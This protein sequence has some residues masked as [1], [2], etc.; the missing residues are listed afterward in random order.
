[1]SVFDEMRIRKQ[2]CDIGKR[3]YDR[4]MVAAND[5]NISV[6]LNDHEILCTPTG[7]SKGYMTPDCICKIN[8]KGEV[9]KA[10][11]GYRPSS[12]M[13]MHLRVYEK[14]PDVGAVVH[15]HPAY[16]TSYAIAGIPLDQPILAEGV[17]MFGAIPVAEYGTPSTNEV[18]DNIEKY[19]PYYD[20]IL[21][22]S[23]GALTWST[24]L[25]S[26]YMR[27]ES[28]EFFAELCYRTKMLGG[29]K[30]FDVAEIEKL[31]AVRRKYGI[32]GR[33]PALIDFD[34]DKDVSLE[35]AKKLPGYQFDFVGKEKMHI[36]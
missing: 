11:K 16:A 15:A 2:I 21:L 20:A 17:V 32:P 26:A 12:E 31:Y 9:I 30:E 28:L 36:S 27:M 3:I 1:M 25:L 10:K 35:E 24:D 19:L 5:G 23:H 13:K 29:P 6:K 18:P 14:R 7:V 8:E 4:N 22:E 34:N 33:H